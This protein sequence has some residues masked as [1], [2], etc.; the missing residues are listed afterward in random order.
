METGGFTL[1]QKWWKS[2]YLPLAVASIG[3]FIFFFCQNRPF[4]YDDL[5]YFQASHTKKLFDYL[6]VMYEA[7]SWRLLIE[8]LWIVIF[9]LPLFVWLMGKL[10]DIEVVDGMRDF[11]LMNY[12]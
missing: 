12:R 9:R 5:A 8:I 2:K 3:Y 7:W 11:R 6:K 1:P 10:T 4:M